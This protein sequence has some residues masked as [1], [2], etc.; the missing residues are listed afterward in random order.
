MQGPPPSQKGWHSGAC[1]RESC[2]DLGLGAQRRLNQPAFDLL[3]FRSNFPRSSSSIVATT[4]PFWLYFCMSRS[5][6]HRHRHGRIQQLVASSPVAGERRVSGVRR[7]RGFRLRERG[8]KEQHRHHNHHHHHSRHHNHHHCRNHHRVV[9][10]SR[11]VIV[12]R[13]CR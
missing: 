11:M 13:R 5:N 12:L 1:Q 6:K 3:P 2:Q 8:E 7:V 9:S 10:V 4:S